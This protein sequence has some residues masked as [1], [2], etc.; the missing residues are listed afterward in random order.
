MCIYFISATGQNWLKHVAKI[1]YI[2][3]YVDCHFVIV[4]QSVKAVFLMCVRMLN[5]QYIVSFLANKMNV[6]VVYSCSA[7]WQQSR[8]M[9]HM[10]VGTVLTIVRNNLYLYH[11]PWMATVWLMHVTLKSYV[12]V[13]DMHFRM[14]GCNF[15]RCSIARKYVTKWLIDWLIDWLA[16]GFGAPAPIAPKPPLI[17]PFV[18]QPSIMGAQPLY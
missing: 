15:K 4:M 11:I 2:T 13:V 10:F 12:R 5:H 18:P 1:K 3:S 16:Y 9:E 14:T 6:A 17:W 7:S 8:V